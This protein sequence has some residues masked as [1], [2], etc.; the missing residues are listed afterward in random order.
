MWARMRSSKLWKPSIE[1]GWSQKY[2]FSTNTQSASCFGHRQ[3]TAFVEM[4]MEKFYSPTTRR[5]RRDVEAPSPR[6]QAINF[7]TT[8]NFELTREGGGW[9]GCLA[10]VRAALFIGECVL[11]HANHSQNG[12]KPWFIKVWESLFKIFPEK[13]IF[14]INGTLRFVSLF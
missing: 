9:G 4:I 7:R 12:S 10:K 2:F 6:K 1:G 8:F 13:Q 5:Q 14:V 11:Y 3:S